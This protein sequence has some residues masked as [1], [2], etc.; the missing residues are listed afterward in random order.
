MPKRQ[1]VMMSIGGDAG[2]CSDTEESESGAPPAPHVTKMLRQLC[3]A[4]Q[5]EA[6]ERQH[7]GER[8]YTV[9][10]ARHNLY[11]QTKATSVA[12]EEQS[13]LPAG[14]LNT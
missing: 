7:G 8:K 9:V 11:T 4:S 2:K 3:G 6:V 13:A 12:Q 10:A 1:S 14:V 5:V